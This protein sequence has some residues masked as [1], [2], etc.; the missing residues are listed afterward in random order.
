MHPPRNWGIVRRMRRWTSLLSVTLLILAA[1][2]GGDSSSESTTSTTDTNP[3][4]SAQSAET[5]PGQELGEELDPA[6]TGGQSVIPAVDVMQVSDGSTVNL[7]S[8]VDAA[9]G[10]EI[11]LWFWAPW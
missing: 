3:A 4:T 9:Q 11:L 7:S 10:R 1:C 5:Q 2:G 6:V 8:I